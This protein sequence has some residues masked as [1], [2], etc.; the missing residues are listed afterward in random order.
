[1]K[2]RSVAFLFPAAAIVCLTLLPCVLSGFA[3]PDV[4]HRPVAWRIEN[5]S[6]KSAEGSSETAVPLKA[7]DSH[8]LLLSD[9]FSK[10]SKQLVEVDSQPRGGTINTVHGAAADPIQSTLTDDATV[11]LEFTIGTEMHTQLPSSSLITSSLQARHRSLCWFYSF[12][13]FV[14]FFL[15]ASLPLGVTSLILSSLI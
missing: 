8:A 9:V 13:R 14:V 3:V 1:M 2:H 5:V 15:F 7:E 12:D 10:T 6:S 11:A 4:I